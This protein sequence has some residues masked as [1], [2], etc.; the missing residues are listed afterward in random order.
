MQAAA[1]TLHLTDDELKSALGS[2]A[3][4]SDLAEQQ[5]VKKDDLVGAMVETL[6]STRT[7]LPD[8]AAGLA[9]KLVDR[10]GLGGPPRHASSSTTGGRLVDRYA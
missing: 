4:L 9:K 1:K 3:S 6:K 2:G 8:D 10:K 7:Q 5:G